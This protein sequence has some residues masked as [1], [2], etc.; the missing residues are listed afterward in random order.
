MACSNPS[1]RLERRSFWPCGVLCVCVWFFVGDVMCWGVW[2]VGVG[3]GGLDVGLDEQG[4]WLV[5]R[6]R[7][8]AGRRA[9]TSMHI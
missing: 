6:H 4:E 8:Q 5:T 1:G 7:R 2:V 3:V 9:D